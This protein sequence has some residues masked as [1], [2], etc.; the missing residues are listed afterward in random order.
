MTTKFLQ[1]GPCQKGL[2]GVAVL[3]VFTGFCAAADTGLTGTW[4]HENGDTYEIRQD[5][6][7]V[8]WYGHGQK[9][10][11][12]WTHVFH[13]KIEGKKII[14]SWA[15]VPPAENRDSGTMT[16]QLIF[17]GDKV[18]GISGDGVDGTLS[19]TKPK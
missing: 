7:A 1:P 16:L 18:V 11:K 17:D 5:G 14:G 9:K 15:D 8:W 19:R 4:Y 2:I 12:S 3:F 10:K 6:S 13:G